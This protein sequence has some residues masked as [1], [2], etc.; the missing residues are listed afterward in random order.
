MHATVAAAVVWSQH[1]V[2]D[3]KSYHLYEKN[4]YGYENSEGPTC[5]IA[6]YALALRL[7]EPQAFKPMIVTFAV[8]DVGTSLARE[9]RPAKQYV[10]RLVQSTM[11][12]AEP[13]D[14]SAATLEV[15]HFH[16]CVQQFAPWGLES[17]QYMNAIMDALVRVPA[18]PFCDFRRSFTN[19]AVYTV[20]QYKLL[21]ARQAF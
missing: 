8:R 3:G 13:C 2:S 19:F 18:T 17:P 15:L 12:G 14:R 4:F 5:A 7:S 1:A 20:P 11:L 10:I 6:W 21:R 16:P 9:R